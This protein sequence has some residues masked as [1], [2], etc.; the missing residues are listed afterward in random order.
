[1]N[2]P[3]ELCIEAV[4][5]TDEMLRYA[6]A[7]L[8]T[9]SPREAER[10]RA[11]WRHAMAALATS[12]PPAEPAPPAQRQP[13][14]QAQMR[15]LYDNSPEIHADVKSRIGFY[16]VVMLAEEAHGIREATR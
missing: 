7:A 2:D 14:T 16:R 15:R 9:G 1:M 6:M 12:P 8:G 10:F 5:L 4:P 3:K 11:F 13:F